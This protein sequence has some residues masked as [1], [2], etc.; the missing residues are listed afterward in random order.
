MDNSHMFAMIILLQNQVHVHTLPA[1]L[2]DKIVFF[3]V[4]FVVL[5]QF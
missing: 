1:W 3:S 5:E 2:I 4:Y